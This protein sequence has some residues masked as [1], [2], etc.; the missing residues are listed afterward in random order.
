MWGVSNVFS[1]LLIVPIQKNMSN[2]MIQIEVELGNIVSIDEKN[3]TVRVQP[4]VTI[5]RLTDYLI[6]LGWMVPIVPEIDDVTVGG[7]ILGG[8]LETT[9]HK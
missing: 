5:G 6:Q 8:G 2:N 7:L 3:K 1:S 9:S 4:R